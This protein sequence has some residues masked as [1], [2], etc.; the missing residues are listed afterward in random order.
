MISTIAEL[1]GRLWTQND[2]RERRHRVMEKCKFRG[3]RT[4]GQGLISHFAD[5]I[6]E[7]HFVRVITL[8]LS[9][10]GSSSRTIILITFQ[11]SPFNKSIRNIHMYAARRSFENWSHLTDYRDDLISS[12]SEL[13]KFPRRTLFHGESQ[14]LATLLTVRI[15]RRIKRRN[16]GNIFPTTKLRSPWNL[17]ITPSHWFPRLLFIPAQGLETPTEY[18]ES[19]GSTSEVDPRVGRCSVCHL[20]GSVNWNENKDANLLFRKK[21]RLGNILLLTKVRE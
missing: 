13:Q 7:S 19:R 8:S 1:I 10:S 2:R 6:R 18:S 5:R 12:V 3:R 21:D 9:L 16:T 15:N 14:S 20:T 17:E 11:R 4:R